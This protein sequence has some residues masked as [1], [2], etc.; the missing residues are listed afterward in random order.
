MK[1]IVALSLGIL[2][3]GVSLPASAGNWVMLNPAPVV[4]TPNT[5]VNSSNFFASYTPPANA[6]ITYLSWDLSPYGNGNTSATYEICML[7][8]TSRCF[9]V[10]KNLQSRTTHFGGYKASSS[11]I[12]RVKLNGGTYPA[13]PT[14][15]GNHMIYVEWE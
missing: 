1:K 6:V 5:Y 4:N 8:G 15:T 12:V 3:A 11:F 14:Y 2:F 9:D 13:Q 10:S 7:P